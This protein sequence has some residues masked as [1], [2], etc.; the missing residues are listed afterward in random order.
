MAYTAS[1][2]APYGGI[3]MPRRL[4][5]RNRLS[6]PMFQDIS[7]SKNECVRVFCF[8]KLIVRKNDDACT[9]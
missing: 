5:H 7:S 6:T 4:A 8:L 3:G 2:G 1:G 9:K